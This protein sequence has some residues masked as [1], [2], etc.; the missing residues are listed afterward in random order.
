MAIWTP[1]TS[2]KVK[3]LGLAWR[4]EELLVGEVEDSTGRVKGVR[5]LGGC[6]DFGETREQALAREFEEELGC[7]ITLAGPWHAFENI[8]EHEGATGH[9]YIFA[10]DVTLSDPRL[11]AQDRFHFRESEESDCWAAWV[12]PLALRADVDLYPPP[13]VELIRAR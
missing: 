11:Y 7:T 6:I 12:A 10:V 13:L 2:I 1:A 3:V 8:Y 4:G 5:P 9:E